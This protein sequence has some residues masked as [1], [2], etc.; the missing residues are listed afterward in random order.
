[1]CGCAR[2]FGDEIVVDKP[3]VDMSYQRTEKSCRFGELNVSFAVATAMAARGTRHNAL[4]LR[5]TVRAAKPQ[6]IPIGH[7]YSIC[8]NRPLHIMVTVTIYTY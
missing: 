6:H 2:S 5:Q 7:R 8:G 3:R 1:M 4:A